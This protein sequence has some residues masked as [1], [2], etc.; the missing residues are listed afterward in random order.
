MLSCQII[1]NLNTQL[2]GKNNVVGKHYNPHILTPNE[3]THAG[4]SVWPSAVV[5]SKDMVS[6]RGGQYQIYSRVETARKGRKGT[7]TFSCDFF[8][9]Q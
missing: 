3:G 6:F 9:S 1:T 2:Q 7:K 5:L 4:E 8:S